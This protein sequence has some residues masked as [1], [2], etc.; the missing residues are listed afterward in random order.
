MSHITALG[1][2]AFLTGLASLKG[3]KSTGTTKAPEKSSSDGGDLTTTDRL[4]EE[5]E[6]EAGVLELLKEGEGEDGENEA[7]ERVNSG[8]LLLKARAFIVKVGSLRQIHLPIATNS[9]FHY[10]RSAGLP[11]QKPFS[12]NAAP[13]P[14]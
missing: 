2:G 13:I 5:E 14:I 11:A 10:P 3:N 12:T 1:Q 6:T 8:N 9:L 7:A 4:G